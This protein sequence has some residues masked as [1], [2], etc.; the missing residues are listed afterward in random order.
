MDHFLV[1]LKKDRPSL[2]C[3]PKVKSILSREIHSP[4]WLGERPPAAFAGIEQQQK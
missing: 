2:A 1:F 4:S 3:D